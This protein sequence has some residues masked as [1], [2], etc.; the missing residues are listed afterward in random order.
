MRPRLYGVPTLRS[1]P[2]ARFTAHAACWSSR[3]EANAISLSSGDHDGCNPPGPPTSM[4]DPVATV[5]TLTPSTAILRDNFAYRVAR[6]GLGTSA[7]IDM[8]PLETLAANPADLVDALNVAF[9]HGQMGADVRASI[10]TAIAAS[11]DNRN[12]ARTALYL[13]LSSSQYQ[14]QH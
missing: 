11:T 7:A 2:V 13:V 6:N 14:V 12:R 4:H 1:A 5:I 10:L 8:T 9:L 3:D